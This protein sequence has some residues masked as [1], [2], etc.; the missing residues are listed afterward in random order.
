MNLS[1]DLRFE[2]FGAMRA[3]ALNER[4][5]HHI[6]ITQFASRDGIYFLELDRDEREQLGID[7]LRA[8]VF[9]LLIHPERWAAVLRQRPVPD[10]LTLR[11]NDG[12]T[13]LWGIRVYNGP[14]P[15]A[16]DQVEA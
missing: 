16:P 15:A 2:V 8:P 10:G 1:A 4:P 12:S 6:R 9:K 13:S 3:M 11:L 14:I 5:I 7:H